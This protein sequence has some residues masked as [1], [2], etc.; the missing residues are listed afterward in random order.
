MLN[1][2]VGAF[3]V[4]APE[5]RVQRLRGEVHLL[6]T[7]WS[8]ED[9]FRKTFQYAASIAFE[10]R[11]R[12]EVHLN[13]RAFLDLT[14]ATLVQRPSDLVH[15]ATALSPRLEVEFLRD[16]V[17]SPLIRNDVLFNLAQLPEL[18]NRLTPDPSWVEV[19]VFA[20]GATLL[21]SYPNR[22]FS[23]AE[24]L[25]LGIDVDRSSSRAVLSS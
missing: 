15:L 7:L 13:E 8:W 4:L 2:D 10:D 3:L 6:Q 14:Y 23:I 18:F 12:K 9:S 1:I 16:F 11:E 20:H 24:L 5:Q 22:S 21:N 25:P 17:R 19:V